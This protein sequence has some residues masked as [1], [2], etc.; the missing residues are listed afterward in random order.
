MKTKESPQ[1]LLFEE[2]PTVSSEKLYK[3]DRLVTFSQIEK[4]IFRDTQQ[5]LD[6]NIN[7]IIGSAIDHFLVPANFIYRYRVDYCFTP[8]RFSDWNLK[9]VFSRYYP[10]GFGFEKHLQILEDH[11]S[12]FI[13][14]NPLRTDNTALERHNIRDRLIPVWEEVAKK[15]K[16]PTYE[17]QE[18]MDNKNN[19]LLPSGKP[20]TE[21]SIKEIGQRIVFEKFDQLVE[22][23]KDYT[24]IAKPDCVL[25]WELDGQT[26][27]IGVQ[28]DYIKTVRKGRKSVEKRRIVNRRIVGDYKD[29]EKKDM[30]NLKTPY[31]KSML[32]Y[33][34]LSTYIG[35]RL[36]QTPKWI[37]TYSGKRRVFLIPET[38]SMPIPEDKVV[39]GLEF[40]RAENMFEPMPKLTEEQ[41]QMAVNLINESLLIS[42]RLKI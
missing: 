24:Y 16:L 26:F 5:R 28:P 4:T 19:I 23:D 11:R 30:R 31:G 25:I 10:T 3:A 39:S 37:K 42:Q 29:S 18:I 6:L 27:H 7:S 35:Q 33:D 12:R 32:V 8:E 21:E 38:V 9:D 22:D 41:K 17:L 36:K 34:F 13:N 40:L 14:N 2:N 1:L 15:F 20:A